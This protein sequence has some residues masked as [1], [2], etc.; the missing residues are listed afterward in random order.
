MGFLSRFYY[1][2][3]VCP[4]FYT[5]ALFLDFFPQ[6]CFTILYFIMTLKLFYDDLLF[7][8]T[9][10][11]FLCLLNL[12]TRDVKSC[13]IITSGCS[14]LCFVCLRCVCVCLFKCNFFW[15]FAC[16]YNLFFLCRW[17]CGTY[18]RLFQQWAVSIKLESFIGN[19]VV[20]DYGMDSS[21]PIQLLP[22]VPPIRT[23]IFLIKQS[24]LFHWY[25]LEKK[26]WVMRGAI[27]TSWS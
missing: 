13:W 25:N 18:F 6:V 10:T 5:F 20:K 12:Q 11:T 16:K 23:V 17:W 9:P 1:Y 2:I 26:K 19:E 24:S 22:W 21:P 27:F 8:F 14:F 7:L 4:V 15:F 3:L